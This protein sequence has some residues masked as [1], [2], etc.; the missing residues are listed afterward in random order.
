MEN[1][2]FTFLNIVESKY[3]NSIE[4]KINEDEIQNFDCGRETILKTPLIIKTQP[5][6]TKK[7][8][9][10]LH[11]K[12]I[13]TFNSKESLLDNNTARNPTD[14]YETER[15]SYTT[16]SKINDSFEVNSS[17]KSK[18]TIFQKLIYLYEN[19][20]NKIKIGNNKGNSR[21]KT[22][23]NILKEGMKDIGVKFS[24][25][26]I[27]RFQTIDKH[28]DSSKYNLI[29][30]S[31]LYILDFTEE[32]LNRN[33]KKKKESFFI[34][35]KAEL[36]N[37]CIKMQNRKNNFRNS[38]KF[39]FP[40]I[41]YKNLYLHNGIASFIRFKYF[42]NYKEVVHK[43][44]NVVNN[45]LDFSDYSERG[46]ISAISSPV[47]QNKAPRKLTFHNASTSKIN[48]K[49]SS[50]FLDK[51]RSFKGFLGK[52]NSLFKNYQIM[53]DKE[54]TEKSLNDSTKDFLN[55]S[56]DRSLS[57]FERSRFV[58]KKN[59]S[60]IRVRYK[61]SSHHVTTNMSTAG[62]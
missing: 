62:I 54:N 17:E 9:F 7:L 4:P 40:A 3:T 24:D 39:E 21:N 1:P 46:A 5:A 32:E 16:M 38:L 31:L 42:N 50:Q 41:N 6:K 51:K 20:G 58:L 2:I 26:E 56:S 18:K 8:S 59:S 10:T 23:I 15:R 35:L 49:L 25:S 22:P 45:K 30:K 34:Y 48:L 52:E 29:E 60:K 43:I 11:S 19:E 36:E 33:Y 55:K 61:N 27:A 14:N 47:K 13:K 37:S 53:L 28:L 12:M 44:E 57:I